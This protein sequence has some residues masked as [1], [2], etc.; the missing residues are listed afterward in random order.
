M[1]GASPCPTNHCPVSAPIVE[2]FS[3]LQGEGLLIG[4]RQVFLRFAGCNLCCAYCDAPGARETPLTARVERP[5]MVRAVS[6]PVPP[7]FDEIPN[8]LSLP[9]IADVIRSLVRPQPG[10]HHSISLTGGEPLLHAPLLAE[11]LPLLGDLGLRAYLETNGTLAEELLKIIAH[12]DFIC[13][14]IKLP[15][16]TRESPRWEEHERFLFA[17]A[18]QEDL[19]RLDFWKCII[20]ADAHPEEVE[21]AARL[22]ASVSNEMPLVLQPVTAIAPG[23]RS[24]SPRQ[25]LDL[26]ALA[27][28]HLPD[29]RIIPQTHRLGGYL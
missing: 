16:A 28:R 1:A 21:R 27:K 7:L 18:A 29:V 3:S 4:Q 8:P 26:Q 24:P 11:L 25:M 23:V 2:I 10:L 15:S 6:Q 9:D 13:A 19:S 17:M 22:I 14:D 12:L 5:A 20:T